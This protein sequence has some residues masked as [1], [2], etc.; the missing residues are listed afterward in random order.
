MKSL[1]ANFKLVPQAA[2]HVH[3]EL[4][5]FMFYMLFLCHLNVILCHLANNQHTNVSGQIQGAQY[6]KMF[7]LP[8]PTP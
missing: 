7:K 1:I 4:P 5:L 3:K 6:K 2:R 8:H